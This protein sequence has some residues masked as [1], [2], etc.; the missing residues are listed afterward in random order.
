MGNIIDLFLFKQI[1]NEEIQYNL[2]VLLD[3][4]ILYYP[5]VEKRADPIA[6]MDETTASGGSYLKT[7]CADFNY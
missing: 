4:G 6:R 2:Y 3:R 1:V 7:G 5:T